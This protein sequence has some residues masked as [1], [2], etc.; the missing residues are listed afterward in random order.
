M[1]DEYQQPNTDNR[2][3]FGNVALRTNLSFFQFGKVGKVWV[4]V[5]IHMTTLL[6]IVAV[7]ILLTSS[8]TVLQEP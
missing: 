3:Y 4:K 5:L 8:V 1:D 6:S 2:Q 7:I